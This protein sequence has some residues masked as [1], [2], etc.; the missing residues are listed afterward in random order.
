MIAAKSSSLTVPLDCELADEADQR[1]A[2]GVAR[3]L[4]VA[5][6]LE[7]LRLHSGELGEI[8]V[9]GDAIIAA[10][11]GADDELDDLLIALR[12]PAASTASAARTDL[13]AAGPWVA[14]AAKVFGTLPIAFLIWA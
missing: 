8:I 9:G 3:G 1:V 6:L 13:R 4:T 14:M 2:L 7:H 11:G 12:V 10:A 5:D